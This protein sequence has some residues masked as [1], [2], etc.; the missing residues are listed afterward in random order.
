[1]GPYST[2]KTMILSYVHPFAGYY[3]DIPPR[4]N[5]NN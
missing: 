3:A 4:Q 1:M 2:H 5:L